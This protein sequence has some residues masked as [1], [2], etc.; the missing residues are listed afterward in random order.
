MPPFMCGHSQYILY[1]LT[2]RIVGSV[3]MMLDLV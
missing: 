2:S 1:A 3:A